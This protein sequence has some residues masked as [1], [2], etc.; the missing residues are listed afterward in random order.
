MEKRRKKDKLDKTLHK[1]KRQSTVKKV[2]IKWYYDGTLNAISNIDEHL[3]KRV[4]KAAIIWVGDDPSDSKITYKGFI[5]ML[6]SSKW[7]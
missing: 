1:N 7:T 4:I 6:Q 5:K 3:D 2:N